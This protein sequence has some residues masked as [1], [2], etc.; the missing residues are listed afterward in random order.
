MSLAHGIDRL[1]EDLLGHDRAEHQHHRLVV[2]L[3]LGE[4]AAAAQRPRAL[5]VEQ[6]QVGA[7][8]AGE[9]A[10][11]RATLGAIVHAG[12][13]VHAAGHVLHPRQLADRFGIG[14]RQRGRRAEA[15]FEI[16]EPLPGQRMIVFLHRIVFRVEVDRQHVGRAGERIAGIRQHRHQLLDREAHRVFRVALVGHGA[17]RIFR[18]RLPVPRLD[19]ELV[20]TGRPH[21]L[22]DGPL[23]AGA[24]GHHCQ[25]GGHAHGDA[26]HRQPRL[27]AVARERL[28]ADV[29]RRMQG[30]ETL[31]R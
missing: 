5:D 29:D 19:G 28:E 11:L 1:A 21:L 2:L 12:V 22:L 26:E 27:Q 4:E 9:P 10:F 15:G 6:V 17:A 14:E 30:A 20:E 31:N 23:R 25:H 24:H 13:A 16:A 3:L 7:V 18:F 8:H